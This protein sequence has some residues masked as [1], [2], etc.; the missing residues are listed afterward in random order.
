MPGV[1]N[2]DSHN[3]LTSWG[4]TGEDFQRDALSE[5]HA[6][7]SQDGADGR[8]HTP[9]AADQFPDVTGVGPQLKYGD[10]FAFD[11]TDLNLAGVIHQ[12]LCDRL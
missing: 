5:L 3:G 9:L 4:G 2:I 1:R 6:S 8:G 10:L 7:R 11:R 12:R